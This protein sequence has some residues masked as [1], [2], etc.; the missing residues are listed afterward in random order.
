MEKK[1]YILIRANKY[2]IEEPEFFDA[3][4]DAH[5]EMK[6]QYEA[7]SNDC[8]GELNDGNAWCMDDN[9]CITNWKIFDM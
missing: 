9:G 7:W 4:Y 2:D 3:Y 8:V 5:K 1:Q 6:R